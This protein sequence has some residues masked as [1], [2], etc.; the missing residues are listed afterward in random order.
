MKPLVIGLILLSALTHTL[1]N[2]LAKRSLNKFIYAWLMKVFEFLIYLP[3]GAYLFVNAGIS[4]IG[5][6][7]VV[8]SGV[9]H[10][11]YWVFL[12][13]SYKYGDLSIVYPISRSSPVFVTIFAVIFLKE[14]L[15]PIGVSG[16]ISVMLGTYLLSMES[17]RARIYSFTDLRSRS[18]FFAF[19]TAL[20]IT[21]YSLV[22]KIGAL[23][24]NPILYVWLFETLSLLLLTPLVMRS[25]E[26]REQIRIEWRD[27]K[28]AAALSGFLVL[29]SYSLIIFVMRLSQLSYI[30]TVRQV[31]V[32]FSVILGGTILKEKNLK[33]RLFSSILIFIGLILIS[34]AEEARPVI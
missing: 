14:K 7:Y 17:L 4:D 2:L 26:N 13:N 31:S 34:I 6:L 11:F 24:V 30:V 5:W 27:N 25:K 20:T 19:L 8:A 32:V 9:I 16:I 21:S 3:I 10:L 12:F 23:Y 22:D 29:F 28:W 1:W 15:L 18:L 33:T